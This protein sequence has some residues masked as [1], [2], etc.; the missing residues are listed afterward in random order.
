VRWPWAVAAA[1]AAVVVH[2]CSSTPHYPR[3][4][5]DV[6]CAAAGKHDY[7]VAGTCVY[8]RDATDCKDREM[9]RSGACLPDPTLQ[10]KDGGDDAQADSAPETDEPPPLIHKQRVLRIEE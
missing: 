6:H 2:A 8:C 1:V 10:L 7:C 4:T 5:S 3:C 9:C